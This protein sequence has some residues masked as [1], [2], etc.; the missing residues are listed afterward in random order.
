MT[1]EEQRALAQ[2]LI[3]NPEY[4]SASPEKKQALVESF[5]R[6]YAVTST[7]PPPSQP[8]YAE[9]IARG[10][11]RAA[12]GAL[13]DFP[14]SVIK[15]E[16]T[17]PAW[18][19][20]GMGAISDQA[21]GIIQSL[22][23]GYKA[24]QESKRQGENWAGQTLATL[25]QYPLIGSMVKQAEKGGTKM[26]SPQ[27]VGAAAEGATYAAA[28]KTVKTIR[29]AI[30]STV[31]A[32][33]RLDMVEGLIGDKTVDI[34]APLKT[35]NELLARTKLTG[36]ISPIRPLIRFIQR[37]Q[38]PL[39]QI[40]A[41]EFM[42]RPAGITFKDGRSFLTDIDTV[43]YDKR[44]PSQYKGPLKKFAGELSDALNK[45]AEENGLHDVYR[46]AMDEFRHSMQII[47]TSKMAG[48]LLGMIAG[49]KVGGAFGHPYVGA[50]LGR[51]AG[52]T[53]APVAARS[54]V[55]RNV[56]T[57]APE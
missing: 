50:Y 56:G 22:Q 40:G 16:M 28:P 37:S 44:L 5:R 4:Q 6:R 20:P 27:S 23:S 32:G 13:Y 42:D 31:R 47:R 7:P 25:E 9:E 53:A 38:A 57:S 43:I 1:P 35:A 19:P 34:T 36:L 17:A 24:R 30:P 2:K 10:A 46:S 45:T 15:S 41:K 49:Y 11:G 14:A 29:E 39:S 33:A 12:K 26:F 54:V 8:G 51:S 55:K 52:E 3:T 18:M 48:K 21:K